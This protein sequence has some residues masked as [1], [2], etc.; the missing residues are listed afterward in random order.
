MKQILFQ[1]KSENKSGGIAKIEFTNQGCKLSGFYSYGEKSGEWI[2]ECL[3]F[4]KYENPYQ[5]EIIGHCFD[6][7]FIFVNPQNVK[8][9]FNYFIDDKYVFLSKEIEDN[10]SRNKIVAIKMNDRLQKYN[11]QK[12]FVPISASY[13]ILK[14]NSSNTNKR[15]PY[16]A[17]LYIILKKRG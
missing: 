12:A 17:Q 6:D 3:F 8:M 14:N 15:Y 1:G 10:F 7:N 4:E 2:E 16:V 9:K 11:R 13:K 5:F